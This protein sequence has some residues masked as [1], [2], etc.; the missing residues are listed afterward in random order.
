MHLICNLTSGTPFLETYAIDKPQKVLLVQTE[1]DR[2]ETLERI[3]KI[4]NTL[5]LNTANWCHM[6][7]DG[8]CLNTPEGFREFLLII[9]K[10]PFKFDVLILDPLYTT[11][12]GSL[13]D[14]DVATDWIRNMRGIRKLYDCA[15]IILSHEAKDSFD[16]RGNLIE[17][18]TEN[19]FGS[20]F[21]LAFANQNFKL[22]EFTSERGEKE[23]RLVR[24][25]NRNNKI[26]DLIEMKLISTDT[27]I[28]LVNKNDIADET[29]FKVI[30]TIEL[31][32][33]P[34]STNTIVKTTGIPQA[35]VYRVLDK[36]IREK[37]I[38]KV[39]AHYGFLYHIIEGGDKL[40]K[41]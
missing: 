16:N 12:K 23:L 39:K 25:K 37:R 4:K 13:S 8:L 36:L 24:G 18:S 5:P 31:S 14:D 35:T 9:R 40:I 10:C 30:K 3:S 6:N 28:R 15:I 41:S 19:L 11:V 22:R 38:K 20:N 21:W 32:D 2:G 1:G 17:K 33:V 26:V 34:V 29:S 27:M 7:W